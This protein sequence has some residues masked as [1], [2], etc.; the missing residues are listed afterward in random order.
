MATPMAPSANSRLYNKRMVYV[1]MCNFQFF[2][3]LVAPTPIA[4]HMAPSGNSRL[5][6]QCIIHVSWC[7]VR[8][9]GPLN[10]LLR[11][12]LCFLWEFETLRSTHDSFF[13]FSLVRFFRSGRFDCFLFCFSPGSVQPHFK[14]IRSYKLPCD[15]AR[16]K[17]RIRFLFF[18][19]SV[20]RSK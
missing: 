4:T 19:C 14:T 5:C 1:S 16:S 8:F 11:R 15:V 2:G 6:Y 20:T 18:G 12:L 3:R 10:G 9:F 17:S 7:H 13:I